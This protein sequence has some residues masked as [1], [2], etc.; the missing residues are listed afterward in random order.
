MCNTF[1]ADLVHT[2]VCMYVCA[3]AL[4]DILA[5]IQAKRF[6]MASS[7]RLGQLVNAVSTRCDQTKKKAR[8]KIIHFTY[9]HIHVCRYMHMYMY[10]YL[11]RK[12]K[13]QTFRWPLMVIRPAWSTVTELRAGLDECGNFQVRLRAQPPGLNTTRSAHPT[14]LLQPNC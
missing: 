8:V 11:V 14:G 2:L 3:S 13:T 12:P 10:R 4:N 9:V 1:Q 7:L 5:C 6:L